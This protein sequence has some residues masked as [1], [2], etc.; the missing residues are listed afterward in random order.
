MAIIAV[1]AK[2]T[3]RPN[4]LTKLN[5][6]AYTRTAGSMLLLSTYLFSEVDGFSV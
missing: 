2:I 6:Q 5:T 4:L 1:M 3:I